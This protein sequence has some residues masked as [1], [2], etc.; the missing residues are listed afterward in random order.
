MILIARQRSALWLAALLALLPL[1]LAV[2]AVSTLTGLGGAGSTPST[3]AL[4]DIPPAYLALYEAAAAKYELDWAILAAIGKVECDHGR[5]P[6]PACT[7]PGA[8]NSAG[9]GGP[10]QFLASTW[11]T[12]GVN[13][14]GR[15][16]PDID[17]WDPVDAIF[18]AANYLRAAGAPGDYPAAIFAYNHS[19]AYVA[20]VEQWAATY[21]ATVTPTIPIGETVPGASATITAQ[22][23]ALPPASAPLAVAQMIAGGDRIIAFPYVYGGGHA[24]PAALSLAD[25]QPDGG[26]YDCSSAVSYVLHAAGLLATA[27]GSGQ[28]ESYGLP[29]PGR[30]VTVYANVGHAFIVVAGIVMNTAWYAPVQPTSPD[31]GPRWQPGQTVSAQIAGDSYGGFVARHPPGL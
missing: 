23:L 18:S 21:R 14:A 5:D 24:T 22:G 20:L 4:D 28:L 26:G 15:P 6:D 19:A 25:P 7:Q 17:R 27:E 1:L 2:L 30:W 16:V 13:P 3:V 29:G 11:A 12:Y 8:T 9:A 31:S 10:M